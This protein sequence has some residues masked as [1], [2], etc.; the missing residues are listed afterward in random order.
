MIPL[1]LIKLLAIVAV[2]LAAFTA[3]WT[4]Q[5]WRR[6]SQERSNDQARYEANIESERLARKAET[7]NANRVILA[8]NASAARLAVVRGDAVAVRSELDR[9]RDDSERAVAAAQGSHASCLATA[10]ALQVVSGQ[11]A[12]RYSELAEKADGHV[13]DIL[14]LTNSWPQE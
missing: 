12:G 4:A 14:T 7:S 11:C 5:G 8:Q 6:D 10:A 3:G 9:L 2:L 1:P 13:S